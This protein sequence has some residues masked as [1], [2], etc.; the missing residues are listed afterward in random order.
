M[1]IAPQLS[2]APTTSRLWVLKQVLVT[3][4]AAEQPYTAQILAAV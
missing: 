1:S 2:P 3:R 4:T